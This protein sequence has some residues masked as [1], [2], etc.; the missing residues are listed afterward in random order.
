MASRM[1]AKVAMMACLG[2]D[3]F[4]DSYLE[5]LESNGIDCTRVRRTAEAATGVA[6]LCVEESGWVQYRQR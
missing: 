4:G 5:N 2:Q 1:G 3:S 6:Q